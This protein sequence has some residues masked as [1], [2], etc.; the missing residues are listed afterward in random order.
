[1]LEDLLKGSFLRGTSRNKGPNQCFEEETETRGCG[2]C[3]SNHHSA[4]H[5]VFTDVSSLQEAAGC[6]ENPLNVED[7]NATVLLSESD[8]EDDEVAND[9]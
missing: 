2:I 8:V 3:G 6:E 5:C 7:S 4:V 9:I 1:M